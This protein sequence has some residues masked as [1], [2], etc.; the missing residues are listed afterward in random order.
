MKGEPAV[1]S[2]ELSLK[3]KLLGVEFGRGLATYA[4]ILLHSGD[5]AWGLPVSPAV[6]T[7][8]SLFDFA[9]PFFLA[10]AFYFMTV[11]PEIG[12]SSQFWKSRIERL[13][14]PYVV[15][16][17]IF[18]IARV[19]TFTLANKAERLQQLLQDPIAVIFLGG[20]S[21]QLYFLPLLLAGTTL[22]LLMPV[23]QRYKVSVPGL[24]FLSSVGLF[25]HYLVETSGNSFQLGHYVAFQPLSNAWHIDLQ[26][27]P[28]L[29]LALVILAWIIRCFPYFLIA[30]ALNRLTDRSKVAL[31][32]LH[33]MLW[34]GLFLLVDIGLRFVLPSEVVDLFAAF[35]LLLFCISLSFLLSRDQ[36]ITGVLSR[37]IVSAGAC[38]F[39]IYLCHPFL[40]NLVKPLIAKALP[41]LATVVS[42]PSVL[43]LSIA[44]FLLSWLFVATLSTNRFLAK[45]LFGVKVPKW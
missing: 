14:I 31:F 13:V 45:Y 2:Q 39:G 20:A 3:S 1:T 40:M 11:K 9:V 28:F 5:A 30:L 6:L 33:P 25:I 43:M 16:S 35:I 36:L 27:Q 21:Y 37:L 12:Y 17:G 18:W 26:H 24:V 44:C 10:T 34:M 8:R 22:V 15:W 38:S 23:L 19:V 42:I 7:L 4:V 32:T 41:T 29:R